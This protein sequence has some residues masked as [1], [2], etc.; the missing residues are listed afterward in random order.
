VLVV[1]YVTPAAL[2]FLYTGL[3]DRDRAFEWLNRAAEEQTEL[4][5]FLAV[6]PPLEPLRADPRFG[7]L[8]R[9]VGF[10]S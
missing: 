1:G 6:Y 5:K 4:I 8:L 3:G 7:V 10:S 2:V 9:R